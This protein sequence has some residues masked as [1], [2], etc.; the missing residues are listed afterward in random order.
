M[1]EL[2]DRWTTPD[3]LTI[4]D[5][6]SLDLWGAGGAGKTHFIIQDCPGPIAYINFDRNAA[7]M[8]AAS[9]RKDIFLRN[10]HTEGLWL[11]DKQAEDKY[12]QFEEA[13]NEALKLE[14][15]TIAVDGGSALVHI[16]EQLALAEYNKAQES[17]GKDAVDRLPTLQRGSINSRILNMLASVSQTPLNFIITHQERQVWSDEGKPLQEFQ[18]RENT[19]VPYGVDVALWM[20]RQWESATKTA[21]A[22]PRYFAKISMCKLPD[23]GNLVNLRMENP[24]WGVLLGYLKHGRPEGK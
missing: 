10:I 15:G 9:E 22:R 21:P 1:T 13:I 11:T 24:S 4:P 19:Q 8:I 2:S 14:E 16:L 17:R 20:F 5:R 6:Y 12:K 18:A 7:R 23:R 3:K